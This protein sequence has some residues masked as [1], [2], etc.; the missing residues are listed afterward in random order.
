MAAITKPR[1]ASLRSVKFDKRPMAA[2]IEV[3][4]GGLAAC[5]DGF[6]QPASGA[7]GEV[8]VGRFAESRSN[9]GGA[10]GDQFVDVEHFRERWVFLLDNDAAALVTEAMR[11]QPCSIL[12]DHTATEFDSAKGSSTLVYDVTSEGV[13]VETFHPA[14]AATGG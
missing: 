3:F 4:K 7:E 5:L 2:D 10:D 14:I 13:W 8:V 6:F 11:E 1:P 12:D 9:D